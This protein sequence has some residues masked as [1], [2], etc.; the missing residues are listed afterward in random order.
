[1]EEFQKLYKL[2]ILDRKHS[3]WSRE[4]TIIGRAKEL[5]GEV[6]EMIKGFEKNDLDNFKEEVGDVLWDLMAL[7]V[8]AEEKE[9]LDTKNIIEEIITKLNRRK[10]WLSG[11]KKVTKEEELRIWKE[12]KS[13]EF[14]GKPNNK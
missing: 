2:L 9:I 5:Q 12:I 1:M 14:K 7:M 3:Q 13:S 4:N 6:E 8:I 11:G 10:P